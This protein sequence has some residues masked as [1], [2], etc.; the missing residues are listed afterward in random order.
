MHVL[1]N[2]HNF[3]ELSGN[4]NLKM[5]KSYQ[6]ENHLEEKNSRSTLKLIF[7]A[8]MCK[9]RNFDPFPKENT[10]KFGIKTQN[11]RGWKW[12]FYTKWFSPWI[13]FKFS[14][15]VCL[16]AQKLNSI[17]YQASV[18]SSPGFLSIL[19]SSNSKKKC[20]KN[21]IRFHRKK[22]AQKVES[23]L[24]CFMLKHLAY[25]VHLLNL[26]ANN[27]YDNYPLKHNREYFLPLICHNK[28]TT[29]PPSSSLLLIFR[30]CFHFFHILKRF[31]FS[32]N[33]TKPAQ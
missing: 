10:C 24:N 17:W 1:N 2:L 30:G 7:G 32:H 31:L 28:A 15:E 14:S 23:S 8:K 4:K 25:H 27:S 12:V 11:V 33:T 3:L 26:N 5:I 13:L 16:Q 6:G 19:P 20:P 9:T 18:Q 21:P 22:N 29:S